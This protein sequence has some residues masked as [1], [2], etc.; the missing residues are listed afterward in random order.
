MRVV[1]RQGNATWHRS[2]DFHASL[3]V[4]VDQFHVEILGWV[5][6]WLLLLLLCCYTLCFLFG[7]LLFLSLLTSLAFFLFSCKVFGR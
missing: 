4:P 3:D 6:Y 7:L 1:E 2:L 5:A